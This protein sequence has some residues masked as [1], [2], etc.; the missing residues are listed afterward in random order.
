MEPLIAGKEITRLRGT[1]LF[2][3][4]PTV[5]DKSWTGG[6]YVFTQK[7]EE[8]LEERGDVEYDLTISV[9]CCLYVSQ[10]HICQFCNTHTTN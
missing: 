2:I 6:V 5:T 8:Y 7:S 10:T 4:T 9:L 3:N 1:L